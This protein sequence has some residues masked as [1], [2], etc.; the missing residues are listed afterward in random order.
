MRQ[1]AKAVV[2]AFIALLGSIA[3]TIGSAFS[4]AL[5]FGAIGL[6]VPGTG[7]PNGNTVS[8]YLENARD[9]YMQGTACNS[10]ANCGTVAEGSPDPTLVGIDYPASFWPLKIFPSWCR[11]GPDGCDKWDVSVDKGVLGLS[12]ALDAAFATPGTPGVRDI[13]V[14]GYSQGGDVVST[15][16]NEYGLTEEQKARLDVVT[17]G[18]IE[19]PD[20]GL[21]QRL[22][23]LRYVPILDVTLGPPMPV[24]PN[25]KTT[26]FGF[27]Y[28]P[29]VYAP[30]YWGNPFAM[31]NAIAAFDNVHGEYLSPNGN[32]PTDTLPYGYTPATLAP[33][34]ECNLGVNCR[35]DSAG[36]EYIMIP[37]TS[38]P[39]MN[40]VMSLTPGALKPLVKPIVDLISP[41]YKVLADLGYD[42]S[43]NPGTPTPLSILPFNPFQN[44]GAVG[45]KLVAAVIQ[46]I[47]D[48]INGGPTLSTPAPLTETASTLAARS[49]APQGVE[50]AEVA[51]VMAGATV[52]ELS[53]VRKSTPEAP[54]EGTPTSSV[55]SAAPST[56]PVVE[57]SPVEQSETNGNDQTPAHEA[58]EDDATVDDAAGTKHD[59]EADSKGDDV[60]DTSAV[61][62]DDEK[63]ASEQSEPQKS[64]PQR[65]EPS[66]SDDSKDGDD[67]STAGSEDKKAA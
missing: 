33:H 54:A 63:D 44:W 8:D 47:Q 30:R 14:F 19:N 38:L 36:N 50:E 23:F 40:L 59:E 12:T 46:G 55:A 66:K 27:E 67:G 48:A 42:W 51:E 60:K 57:A 35:L 20:G 5:A 45:V 34:L 24:D 10:E 31:L 17:I 56:E 39:I 61:T 21:W 28:D 18:G 16:L 65:S 6:L 29:V 32:G 22:G 64:E 1:T 4:A 26:T 13:V 25:I 9:W 52:T 53:S 11:S 58:V 62:K 49:I 41:A 2:L 37:A 7:T 15:T 3:L 43:G